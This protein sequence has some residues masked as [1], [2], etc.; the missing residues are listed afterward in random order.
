MAGMDRRYFATMMGELYQT[1]KPTLTIMDGI[2]A[3]H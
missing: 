1:I 3:I 2:V